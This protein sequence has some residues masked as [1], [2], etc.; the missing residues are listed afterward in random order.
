LT[1]EDP[2]SPGTPLLMGNTFPGVCTGTLAPCPQTQPNLIP[3]TTDR[4][5]FIANANGIGMGLS[6]V[7]FNRAVGI[8]FETWVL[9]MLPQTKNKTLYM[10]PARMNANNGLPAGVIPDYVTTMTLIQ[11]PEVVTLGE[12]KAVTGTLTSKSNYSQVLGLIDVTSML[13]PVGTSTVPPALVFTTTGNTTL[14]SDVPSTGTQY[15]VA[16]W[17]QLVY[18]DATI[19]NDPNPDLYL[20]DTVCLNPMVYGVTTVQ[21]VKRSGAHSKLT[22]P[23]VQLTPIP[24]DPDPPEVQ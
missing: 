14:G 13:S 9:Y 20:W 23:T 3:L 18:E 8:A 11:G 24:G 12:V 15:T 6:G 22:A 21:S 16:I 2:Q 1:C 10:S 19:P 4:L 7:Q 17:Q 5:K